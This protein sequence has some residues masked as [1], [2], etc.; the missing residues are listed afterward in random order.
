M[1]IVKLSAPAVLGEVY[2]LATARLRVQIASRG[3]CVLGLWAADR[4]GHFDDV[5]LGHGDAQDYL[6]NSVY[7]GALIGRYGNRIAR[8]E[9]PLAGQVYA[10]P[11]N[12]G[13]NHLHGGPRGFHTVLWTVKEA[14][15]SDEPALVLAYES[16]DGEAGYPGKL[17]VEVTYTV[18]REPALRVEYSACTDR[19]TV[20]NLTQHSYFNLGAADSVDSHVLRLAA[21]RFLPVDAGLIPG[22]ELREVAA[23]PFD[24]RSPTAVGA[25][26][27]TPDVQLDRGKGYDHCYVI[28]GWDGSLRTMAE[29]SEPRSGRRLIMRTTEPGVQFYSG[30]YL[31][32]VRG[33]GRRRDV[34]RA[35]LCR[36]AQHFPDSPHHP[37]FPATEL[38]PGDRYRQ[39]TEYAFATDNG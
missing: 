28:D 38:G 16:A 37:E 35:G 15:H 34:P 31:G 29:L 18:T 6:E 12:N 4:D 32:G 8:G 24:F 36:E 30:N 9:L 14:R 39:I 33:K 5:V 7:F 27:T 23:T 26:L 19:R 10:L 2:E 3:G 17:S 22:G 11:V 13:A 1:S 20:I 25:R 21:S